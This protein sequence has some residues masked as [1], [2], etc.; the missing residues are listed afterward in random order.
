MEPL[1]RLAVS[2]VRTE[3]VLVVLKPA[4]PIQSRPEEGSVPDRN[5]TPDSRGAVSK[6][7][8]I[9]EKLADGHFVSTRL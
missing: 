4:A 3:E 9:G 1:V 5:A 6:N 2:A 7:A 8:H